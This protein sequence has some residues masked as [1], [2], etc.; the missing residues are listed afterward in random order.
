MCPKVKTSFVDEDMYEEA[1]K[2]TKDEDNWDEEEG[3]K[4]EDL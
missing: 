3:E 4:K 1:I 2:D